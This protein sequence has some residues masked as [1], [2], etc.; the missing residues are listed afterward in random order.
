MIPKGVNIST[1]RHRVAT[2]KDV[3]KLN[4]VHYTNGKYIVV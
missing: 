2:G 1:H 3:D 4:G